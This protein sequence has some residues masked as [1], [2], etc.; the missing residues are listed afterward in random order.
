MDRPRVGVAFSI[1]NLERT[2]QRVTHITDGVDSH[3]PTKRQ[4]AI[5]GKIS[6]FVMHDTAGAD[7]RN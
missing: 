3:H 2:D 7:N 1:F 6:R 5:T 4:C